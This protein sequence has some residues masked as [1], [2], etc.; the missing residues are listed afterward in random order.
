MN[1]KN[2]ISKDLLIS[3][4]NIKNID[5]LQTQGE[6]KLNDGIRESFSYRESCNGSVY[7]HFCFSGWC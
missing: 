1:N 7:S 2:S 3:N 5:E 6:N 4:S